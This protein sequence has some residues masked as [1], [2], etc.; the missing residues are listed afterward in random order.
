MACSTCH[1]IIDAADFV[2]STPASED[3]EDMLDLAAG[4]TRFSRLACQV[5]LD[6]ALESITVTIPRESRNMQGR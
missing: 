6:P 4:A 2:K 3:E 1:V 5:L